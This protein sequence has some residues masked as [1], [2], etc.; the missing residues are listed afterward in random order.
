MA[1]AE[2][3]AIGATPT[4]QDIRAVTGEDLIRVALMV[5]VSLLLIL[6]WLLGD[7]MLSIV[8]L[9][10]TAAGY[11]ATLGLTAVVWQATVGGHGLDWKIDF[12][13]F[14][15]LAAVGQDYNIF[16]VSRIMEEAGKTAPADGAPEE[17]AA[18]RAVGKTG[19]IISCCGVVMA[20]TF[21]SMM[22]APLLVMRQ[23][24]FALAAGVLIDTFLLR[25]LLVPAAYVL[26]ERLKRR[27]RGGSRAAAVVPTPALGDGQSERPA[28]PG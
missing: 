20:V 12:F 18:R 11:F 21:G 28:G 25:P 26:L 17:A 10:A 24:G 7:L 22:A 8:L 23:V 15:I 14:C 3:H 5:G 9:G 19:G 6:L 27:V 16:I 2:V 13:L 1:G 4:M